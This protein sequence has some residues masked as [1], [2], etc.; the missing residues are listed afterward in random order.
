M[1]TSEQTPLS[2]NLPI[3]DGLRAVAIILVVLYHYISYFSFGWVGVDL[4]FVLSGFL[5]TGKL[6]ESVGHKKYY[7]IFLFKR[8]LRIVPLYYLVLLLIFWIVPLLLPALIS[9]SYQEL[10]QLQAVYWLFGVNIIDAFRGW[11]ENIILIHVW[12]LSCEIQFYLVWPIVV[13]NLFQKPVKFVRLLFGL[14]IFALLFRLFASLFFEIPGI[15]RYVLLFSRID[16]FAL[17]A[18]AYLYWSI[19]IDKKISKMIESLIWIIPAIVFSILILSGNPWHF[20]VF[21][22]N[23]FGLTLNALFF[24]AILFVTVSQR[25]KYLTVFLNNSFL[26][27]IGRYSYAI[28]LFHIPVFLSVKKILYTDLNNEMFIAFLAALIT[29][30]FSYLSYNFYESIF[31]KIKFRISNEI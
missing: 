3:L 31:M 1:R 15:Y 10:I 6:T 14:I 29:L 25:N 23:T 2:R 18:I 26:V 30:F 21:F 16:A 13:I 5:I 22:V 4:F 19:S 8:F 9:S 17:G 24:F 11:P 28:Y 7:R 20:S 12:S 27:K